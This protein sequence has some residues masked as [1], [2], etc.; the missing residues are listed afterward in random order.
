M[1]YANIENRKEREK[2]YCS[3]RIHEKIKKLDKKNYIE[4]V[5]NTLAKIEIDIIN[6]EN[7]KV[8]EKEDKN[9][10]N[11][12]KTSKLLIKEYDEILEKK[13][14]EEFKKIIGNDYAKILSSKL[15]ERKKK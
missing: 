12:N 2:H 13:I 6:N 11:L 10:I 4:F 7:N 14:F 1:F 8:K 15:I 5:G 9:E 3:P